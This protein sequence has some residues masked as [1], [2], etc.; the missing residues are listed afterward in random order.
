MK[1]LIVGMGIG[2]L[3]KSIYERKLWDITTVDQNKP[4]DYWDIEEVEGEFDIVHICTPN[5][6]HGTIA[7]HI[8]ERSK[9][10]SLKSLA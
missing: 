5:F 2:E 9:L 7:R 8:A 1:V 6:T 3:Y 10:Y 4:A